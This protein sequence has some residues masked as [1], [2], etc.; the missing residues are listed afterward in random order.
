MYLLEVKTPKG[1]ITKDNIIKLPDTS[2]NH[3]TLTM[4][5][6]A[7]SRI[8]W[9]VKLTIWTDCKYVAGAIEQ[10]WAQKWERDGW[11]NSKGKPVADSDKWQSI[12]GKIRIHDVSVKY[13]DKHEYLQWMT[14]ELEK[15][16]VAPV[17]QE[18]GEHV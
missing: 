7:L 13:N 6:E 5:D 10:A 8:K 12:L 11:V 14:R 15:V 2:E 1:T 4:L 16:N 17:Q 9:G 3:L 18:G